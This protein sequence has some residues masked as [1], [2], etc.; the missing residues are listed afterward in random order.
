MIKQ[1][2]VLYR[3]CTF[4]FSLNKVRAA[5]GYIYYIDISHKGVCSNHSHEQL[6]SSNSEKYHDW[7]V[8]MNSF[9]AHYGDHSKC[10]K[11]LENRLSE[12]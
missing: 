12:F 3:Q 2:K 4:T 1:V 7:G 5:L 6:V 10:K 11:Y 8:A 9:N